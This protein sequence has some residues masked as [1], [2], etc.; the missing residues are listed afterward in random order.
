L[1]ALSQH[2]EF[3]GTDGPFASPLR[4][5]V[6]DDVDEQDEA[7]SA[8]ERSPHKRIQPTAV[9]APLLIRSVRRTSK[10]TGAMNSAGA[11]AARPGRIRRG[12]AILL[13]L[14]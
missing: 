8:L 12:A 13:S 1:P 7:T 5:D 9:R 2:P 14:V 10:T 4:R 6:N 3:F 11:E